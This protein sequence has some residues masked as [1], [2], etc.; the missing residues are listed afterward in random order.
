MGRILSIDYGKRRIGLAASDP[1]GI[2]AQPVGL[3]QVRS[4]DEALREIAKVIEEREV[5]EIVIGMPTNM[6]GTIG[7]IAETVQAFTERLREQSG[8]P[9]HTYD[10][11][12]TSAL[13][14]RLLKAK[15]VKPS[16]R[17]GKLDVMSAQIILQDFLDSR[18]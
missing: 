4:D 9:V 3:L 15:G 7:P 16:Q 6:D 10:E 8:L 11:R 1:L 2:T 13:A 17:K 18:S 14:H 12:L 5:D